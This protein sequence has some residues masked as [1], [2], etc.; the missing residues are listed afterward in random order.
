M[1]NGSPL[2]LPHKASGKVMTMKVPIV[3]GGATMEDVQSLLKKD[4][5]KYDSIDCIY[6]VNT[7]NKLTGV[8]SVKEILSH[9]KSVKI[10]DIMKKNPI[11]IHSHAHQERIAYAAL[12][13]NLKSVPVIDENGVFLG[14]VTSHEILNI[15]YNETQDDLFHSAGVRKHNATDN[16]LT[17]S[18][19]K[20][21]RHRLPWLI[22][23]LIGGIFAAEIVGYFE[24]TLEK[25]IIL[26]TFIPLIVY[27]ADAVKTQ[28]EIFIVRDMANDP[29]IKFKKYFIKQLAVVFALGII[30]SL[31][32]MLISSFIY[33]DAKI[34]TVLGVGLFCAIISSMFAGLAIPYLFGKIKIDPANASGPIATIIQDISSIVIYFLVAS[35]LL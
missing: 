21:L 10:T 35:Y 3:S 11:V 16:I 32:L 23:G 28:M 13:N 14:A 17:I 29:N 7:Q 9:A 26:A 19:W 18:I 4:A 34:S 5:K 24:D 12:K 8:C 30:T 20:S 33:G 2:A 1:A 27:M 25:H 6:I 22:V 15:L 31:L